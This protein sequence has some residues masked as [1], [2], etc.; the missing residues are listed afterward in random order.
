MFSTSIKRSVATL[1]VVAGLLA[2]AGP[3]SA[4]PI[5]MKSTAL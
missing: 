5:Y 2:A 4:M 3:A 1:G